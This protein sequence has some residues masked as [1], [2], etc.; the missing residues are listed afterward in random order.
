M[1]MMHSPVSDVPQPSA[2]PRSSTPNSPNNTKFESIH[3]ERPQ[4]TKFDGILV[5]RF[6]D[7]DANEVLKNH[8]LIYPKD[9]SELETNSKFS[10][11]RLKQ[12][13][14]ANLN[15]LSPSE[16]SNH[17]SAKA[18]KS[19]DSMIDESTS[20]QKKIEN[21]VKN[22]NHVMTTTNNITSLPFHPFPL[23]YPMAA[24]TTNNNPVTEMDIERLKLVR[25]MATA[26][27]RDLNDCGFRI[28]FGG[29]ATNYAH[30]DTSEELVVDEN[31][32][33]M[34][35]TSTSIAQ[36]TSTPVT[37]TTASTTVR[38][39]FEAFGVW[40]KQK[41]LIHQACPVDLTRTLADTKPATA[42]T[43][44]KDATRK[45]AFS[46]EN[47]LDPNKFCPKKDQIHMGQ[48]WIQGYERDEREHIEDESDQSGEQKKEIKENCGNSE[49]IPT[50]TTL[51]R[52]N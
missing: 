13:S 40:N 20:T 27:G 51:M 11:E 33:S 2:S 41:H 7:S 25:N 18:E 30:S 9:L 32:E 23:K 43:T 29:L 28:Q 1:V 34:N 22:L 38:S 10:I 36:T 45:L 50:T 16:D 5:A 39:A 42:T 31:N 3:L 35:E 26:N 48:H 37:P 4:A 14:N 47:I 44:E 52:R 19:H 15:R 21:D 46:V 49:A 8:P 6:H 17:S 24:L 12:L